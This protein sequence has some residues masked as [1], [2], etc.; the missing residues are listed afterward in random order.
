[1]RSW[2]RRNRNPKTCM[3][4]A[5]IQDPRPHTRASKTSDGPS[6]QTRSLRSARR[7]QRWVSQSNSG[8]P[9]W[10]GHFELAP[11]NSALSQIS[12]T[13][14]R[15]T[16]RSHRDIG[17]AGIKVAIANKFPVPSTVGEAMCTCRGIRV[18][19]RDGKEARYLFVSQYG[20]QITL[21]LAR[22]AAMS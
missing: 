13:A 12:G 7:P 15:T 21:I 5:G 8:P 1:M 20:A 9:G 14:Q 16:C 11:N 2:T 18:L 6:K 3:P 22:I 19:L 10:G 4:R 17:Q